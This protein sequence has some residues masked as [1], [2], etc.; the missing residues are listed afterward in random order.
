MKKK[1]S[2]L[3]KDGLL[4]WV[5]Q[6]HVYAKKNVPN[7]EN[8]LSSIA[9][10]LSFEE[11]QLRV[12]ISKLSL[13]HCENKISNEYILHEFD[14]LF[15]DD[16]YDVLVI[17]DEN[18][19]HV[20]KY[21]TIGEY[22]DHINKNIKGFMVVHKGECEKY[23]DEY[24]V[25]IICSANKYGSLLLGMYMY[26]LLNTTYPVKKG[27]IE[28]ARGYKNITG[29]CAYNKFGFIRDDDLIADNCFN[30]PKN[31][32]MSVDLSQLGI[33]SE[34]IIKV[35]TGELPH[36]PIENYKK[37]RLCI[38]YKPTIGSKNKRKTQELI[39]YEMDTYR[40]NNTNSLWENAR[41]KRTL[42]ILDKAFNQDLLPSA[43]YTEG[44][45]VG[46]IGS[47][48]VISGGKRKT[49]KSNNKIK[50]RKTRKSHYKTKKRKTY[51]Q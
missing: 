39:A 17:V 20:D 42:D 7:F 22:I 37:N 16:D 26:T 13:N 21:N 46:C 50:K 30:D 14:G 27:I 8:T 6:N 40:Q 1:I 19:Q 29:L 41:R 24:C 49:R 45:I 11:Y 34:N 33:T 9:K 38:T 5:Q 51:K 10:D 32:P 3:N 47:N 18:Y 43:G 35:V 2:V 4:V 31:M 12:M 48:C 25:T 44:D 36:L 23:K 28:L 15:T